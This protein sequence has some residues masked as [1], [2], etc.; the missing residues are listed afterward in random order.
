MR[1]PESP[2]DAHDIEATSIMIVSS[3]EWVGGFLVLCLNTASL[4]FVYSALS[5]RVPLCFLC[6]RTRSLS[7]FLLHQNGSSIR[8]YSERVSGHYDLSKLFSGL[9]SLDVSYARLPPIF[10]FVADYTI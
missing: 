6:A 9:A 1:L 2:K 5:F 8:D 7:T 3:F 10:I 4:H